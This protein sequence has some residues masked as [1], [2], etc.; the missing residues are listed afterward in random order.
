MALAG[1][2]DDSIFSDCVMHGSRCNAIKAKVDSDTR[3]LRRKNDKD[4][5]VCA[6]AQPKL[7]AAMNLQQLP[8]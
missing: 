6:N 1:E 3:A 2:L 4:K 7:G 8:C 5:Q